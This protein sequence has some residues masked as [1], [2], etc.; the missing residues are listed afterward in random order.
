MKKL[1]YTC[2]GTVRIRTHIETNG[3]PKYSIYK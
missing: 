3:D 2:D 1:N